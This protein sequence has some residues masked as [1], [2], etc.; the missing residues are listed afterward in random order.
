MW[1]WCMDAVSVEKK[2]ENS[3]SYDDTRPYFVT[4]ACGWSSGV[5]SFYFG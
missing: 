3:D 5:S 1:W 4:T 2:S